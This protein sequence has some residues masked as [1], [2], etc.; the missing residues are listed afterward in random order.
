M[1]SQKHNAAAAMAK[2]SRIAPGM[3]APLLI[4]R[5]AIAMVRTQSRLACLTWSAVVG[6]SAPTRNLRFSRFRRSA[7][8][9]KKAPR[10]SSAGPMGARS[11]GNGLAPAGTYGNNGRIVSAVAQNL[12]P[13]PGVRPLLPPKVTGPGPSPLSKPMDRSKNF[14]RPSAR[15]AA[16]AASSELG[17]AAGA[18]RRARG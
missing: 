11:W 3:K 9:D 17:C 2:T 6:S 15:R 7:G 8:P 10:L 14:F 4:S 1:R 18:S 16:F 12:S 5:R 13:T